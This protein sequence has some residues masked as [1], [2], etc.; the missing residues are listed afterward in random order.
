MKTETIDPE[1]RLARMKPGTAKGAYF[2]K[3]RAGFALRDAM[4]A[5]HLIRE[6]VIAPYTM[7]AG[8]VGAVKASEVRKH[9]A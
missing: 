9:L 5:I 3:I 7:L 8:S 6:G 1:T 2:L 4:C